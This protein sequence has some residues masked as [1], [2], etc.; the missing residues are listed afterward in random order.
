MLT[1]AAT[2]ATTIARRRSSTKQASYWNYTNIQYGTTD[3]IRQ[4]LNIALPSESYYGVYM[5]HHASGGNHF[6]PNQKFVNA[7]HK[8]GYAMVSWES[9]TSAGGESDQI[10]MAWEWAQECFDFILSNSA[11]YGWDPDRIIIGGRSL[12]SVVSWKIAH[13]SS[14]APHIVGIYM[15]NALPESIWKNPDVWY[16]PNDVTEESPLTYLVYGPTSEDADVHNPINAYPIIDKYEELGIKEERLTFIEGMWRDFRD[17]NG[18]WINEYEIMH[19]FPDLA[20][21]IE[22]G[23]GSPV[24]TTITPTTNIPSSLPPSPDN[25]DDD[26]IVVAHP[27]EPFT[28]GAN[29]LFIG[30]SFF[31]P[32]AR[33]FRDFIVMANERNTPSPFPQHGFRAEFSGGSSGTPGNL[34]LDVGHRTA[35]DASLSTGNIELFGMTTF[36]PSSELEFQESFESF[37][38]TGLYTSADQ[39]IPEYVQWIDLAISYNPDTAILIGIPWLGQN[40]LLTTET[41]KTM[42]E[43]ACEYIHQSLVLE[44]R[45]L[46]PNNQILYMCYGPVASIMRQRFDNGMLPDIT[47]QIGEGPTALFSDE[48]PGHAGPMLKEMAA[49]AWAQILYNGNDDNDNDAILQSYIDR[50][51]QWDKDSVRAIL[52]EVLQFNKPYNVVT[53]Q[54]Q[55]PPTTP[56]PTTPEP[57]TASPTL[58]PITTQ[59]SVEPSVVPTSLPSVEPTTTNNATSPTTG[60]IGI[61]FPSE[62]MVQV[63]RKGEGEQYNQKLSMTIP[64]EELQIGDYVLTANNIISRQF[65]LNQKK[66]N[67]SSYHY[68]ERVYNFG[69]HDPNRPMVEYLRFLPSGLELSTN[70]YVYRIREG[71]RKFVP[72]QQVLVGD[73]LLLSKL[74]KND[75]ANER[76][77]A[78]S[79]IQIIIAVT[80]IQTVRRRGALAP[81]TPS[82]TIVVNDVL[83]STYASLSLTEEERKE[84][85]DDELLPSWV[86]DHY[87]DWAHF[88]TTI[89][90]WSSILKANNYYTS[91]GLS[92]DTDRLRT[93]TRWF[94]RQPIF[95]QGLLSLC[96]LPFLGLLYA[97]EQGYY[98]QHQQHFYWEIK[99]HS[100]MD[101]PVLSVLIIMVI[102]VGLLSSKH[103]TLSIKRD[104]KRRSI[105]CVTSDVKLK[106]K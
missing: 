54:Q 23:G 87:Q 68:Y 99:N 100:I 7:V 77:T 6:G 41:L 46:Y 9:I 34:W 66:E 28:K 96:V 59:P 62:S 58:A 67:D 71:M 75:N 85:D 16:P 78:T 38:E 81:L 42:M 73:R 11:T 92:M 21:K 8:S 83:A 20:A 40:N 80:G 17:E 25:D 57:T 2:R 37:Q 74:S 61:C 65:L 95:F 84:N 4:V 27:Y 55:P 26:S 15:Y 76:T 24:A 33:T 86:I 31:V 51:T 56:V 53:Q 60:G 45:R 98:Y 106:N 72:A 90:R 102:V 18:K 97:L 47:E 69:H 88:I 3:P 63:L 79:R 43:F 101:V 1:A 30:N 50:I 19:Y 64:M 29:G 22:G 32:I 91:D 39:Y 14:N 5:F 10:A 105:F 103:F 82:G 44:L 104:P 93:M 36:E 13:S 52:T 35:I 48:S 70:H 12:G 94:L 49:I 89:L